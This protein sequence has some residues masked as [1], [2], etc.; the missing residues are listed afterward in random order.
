MANIFTLGYE[1]AIVIPRKDEEAHTLFKS[2]L[3]QGLILCFTLVGA[4][5]IFEQTGFPVFDNLPSFW[6]YFLPPAVFVL[7]VINVSQEYFN[8]VHQ[9][10][11]MATGRV[12]QSGATSLIQVIMGYVYSASIWLL[13]G[14]LIGRLASSLFY[15]KRSLHQILSSGF[16]LATAKSVLRKFINYPKYIFPTVV[17]DR[18]SIEAPYL[19]FAFLFSDSFVGLY[20]IAFRVIMV[21]LTFLGSAIG[22]VFFSQS[23][24]IKN[25]NKRLSP[26]LLKTWA[27]LGAI[28]LVPLVV[29]WSGGADLFGF[30]FGEEWAQTGEIAILLLPLMYFDFLSS[31]TGRTFLILKLEYLSTTFSVIRFITT[32]GSIWLGY[33]LGSPMLSLIIYSLSRAFFLL[34]QNVILYV[35]VT[36]Y[37][38]ALIQS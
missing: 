25:S 1:F 13:A 22:Q 6:I 16:D 36:K 32:V 15:L 18:L 24:S 33:Y 11:V 30:V 5:F 9:F 31:P 28:G 23:A 35:K 34:I 12:L 21:P 38:S 27:A 26:I 4:I 2:S 29:I 8:R 20:A 14:F 3:L 37:D 7:I 19:L 10:R 17:I